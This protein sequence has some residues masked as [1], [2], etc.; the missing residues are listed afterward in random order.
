MPIFIANFAFS[1]HFCE[2]WK[3]FQFLKSQDFYSLFSV[4]NSANFC[5]R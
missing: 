3:G 4:V 2:M 5:C 1:R